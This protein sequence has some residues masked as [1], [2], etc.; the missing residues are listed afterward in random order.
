[1]SY[2]RLNST[3]CRIEFEDGPIENIQTNTEGE[4]VRN[5]WKMIIKFKDKKR[6]REQDRSKTERNNNQNLTKSHQKFQ[7]MDLKSS[8]NSK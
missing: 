4:I 6:R 3:D 5:R 2:N 8:G 1:M 7:V